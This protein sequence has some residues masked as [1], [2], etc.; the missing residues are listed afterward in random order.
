MQIKEILKVIES[1]APPVLQENYD[2]S[3]LLVGAPD[4]EVSGVLLTVD[5]TEAVLEEASRRGANLIISHHPLIFNGLKK[6]VGDNQTEKT[7]IKAIR[8]DIA[9]YAAHTNLD[10]IKQG[11][12]GKLCKK[13]ELENCEVLRPMQDFLRKLVVFVPHSHA[14]SVRNGLF[15]AGAGNI[16]EY[17]ECS[18]NLEGKGTFKPSE[19]T[20]PYS[21]EVGKL[22]F[23]DEV[24]IEV[25]YPKHI[26][27]NVVA[28]MNE[29]HPYEE[30]AYDIFR[31]ANEYNEFGMGMIGELKTPVSGDYFLDKVK[32]NLNTECIRYNDIDGDKNISKI[33]VC[34]GSGSFLL[35]DAIAAG[36]D[37]FITADVKYHDFF[38]AAGKLI[39]A[40]V[41]HYESE[42]VTK[43]IFYDILQKNFSNFA[44]HLS[45]INTNPINYK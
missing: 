29:T 16:G 44:I 11:V 39:L 19:G 15:E 24:R 23:E 20:N 38:D 37:M 21:G 35:N 6:L 14:D 9:V 1:E 7:L 18:Y 28:K 2:N 25:V 32:R 17:G 12:N 3:G 5:V 26:E 43:E 10:S 4:K 36:A 31:L 22:Q 41:G 42:K 30:V 27:G 33:A 8:E 13:L 40:D 45:N 34:G